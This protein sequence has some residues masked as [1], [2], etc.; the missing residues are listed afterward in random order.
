MLIGKLVSK[1]PGEAFF[2]YAFRR[3][4]RNQD[5]N[6]H[7]YQMKKGRMWLDIVDLNQTLTECNNKLRFCHTYPEECDFVNW[8]KE[9]L[10]GGAKL[11]SGRSVM[12]SLN[13]ES[14]SSN[15][16]TVRTPLLPL[17]TVTTGKIILVANLSIIILFNKSLFRD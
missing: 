10:R 5:A 6:Y 17:F 2:L 4:M 8:P 15:S 3:C 12:T 13:S 7:L 14:R 1:H 9:I 16:S 11:R